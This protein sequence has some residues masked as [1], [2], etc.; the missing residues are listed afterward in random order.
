[1]A[2]G[3]SAL[4][5]GVPVK[6][7]ANLEDDMNNI[8]AFLNTNNESLNLLKKLFKTSSSIGMNVNELTKL[9]YGEAKEQEAWDKKRK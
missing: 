9:S 5:I 6:I 7:S 3:A 4:A 8:N 2:K 1:M